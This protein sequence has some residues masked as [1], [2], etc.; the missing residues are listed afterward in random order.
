MLRNAIVCRPCPA[1]IDGIT[2][3]NLG[4]PVYSLA[5]KVLE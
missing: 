1:I 2:S 3:A 5:I 4:K